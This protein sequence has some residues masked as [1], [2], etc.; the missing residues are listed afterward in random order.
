MKNKLKKLLRLGF[1]LFTIGLLMTNCEK[2]NTHEDATQIENQEPTFTIKQYSRENIEKNTKLVSRLKEFNDNLIEKKSAKTSGKNAYNKEYDFTI[3]TDSATYIQNGDYHS[4]T[5]PIVQGADDK[6]TNVLFELNDEDEYDAFL[7]EYDYSA[8]EFNTLDLSSLS[9]VTSMEPI[10]FD[11]NSLSARTRLAYVC[12]YTYERHCYDGWVDGSVGNLVG[13]DNNNEGCWWSLK[14]GSCETVLYADEDY[15]N[16]HNNNT[17]TVTIGGTTYG[18]TSGGSSTSPMPSPFDSEELMK[19]NVVKSELELNHPERLWIDEYINAQIAFKLYDFGVTHMWSEEVK[20]FAKDLINVARLDSVIDVGAFNFVLE[21]YSHNKIYN[22]FDQAF[23]TSVNQFTNI[24]TSN[25][26]NI[27]PVYI[28]FVMKCIALRAAH[29]DWSDIKIYWEASK[30]IVHLT[31]DALGLIPV[32]GE[33]C[34]A[35]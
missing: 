28:H 13:A 32:F 18:G 17:A 8:N 2:D 4:Y 31:L 21:A 16:Y 20:V 29:P 23:L 10:D 7:V 26:A 3:Y 12:I 25:N 34:G 9:L 11:F 6:I 22:A 33:P 15:T 5:F 30:D 35:F 1:T 24:D 14:A 19:I 27:D